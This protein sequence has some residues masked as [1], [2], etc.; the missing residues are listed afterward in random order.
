MPA[1]AVAAH[2]EAEVVRARTAA[3]A[4]L[5]VE[6]ARGEAAR[7]RAEAE[8]R[9]LA[10]GIVRAARLVAE[11]DAARA[12]AATLRQ[13][14]IA[15]LAIAVARRILQDCHEIDPDLAVRRA[16]ETIRRRFSGVVRVRASGS[17]A[18]AIRAALGTAS[19]TVDRGATVEADGTLP[20]GTCVIEGRGGEIRLDDA[21][22]IER[23]RER[24]EA[25]GRVRG[26][27]PR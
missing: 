23:M 13:E 16:I 1:D 6:E 9:G 17:L 18:E 5:I 4:E 15:E 7:I 3:Q 19:Q 11:A 27:E 25:G 20:E 14:E 24:L 21:E 26:G 22:M 8:Q 12:A 10:E 2:R